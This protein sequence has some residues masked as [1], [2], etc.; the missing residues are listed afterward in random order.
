MPN[1]P[2]HAVWPSRLP[3]E[4]VIPATT[5]WFNLEVSARRYPDK[6]ACR[7]FGRDLSY[8]EL[9]AQAEALAGWL[10][11]EGLQAG[12]RVLLFLQNCPQFVV[13]FY[14]VQRA[15][16]VVVPV[17]PMNK[18][19]EFGHYITDPQARFAITSA[20]LAAIVDAADGRLP[21]DRR[22]H[23]MLVTRYC[24]AM[25]EGGPDPA[26][27]PSD[28]VLAWLRADPPL[29]AGAVRWRDALAA[30][31]SPGPHTAGPDDLAVL[32]YTSG[33]TGLP[34][35]CMHT[36]R[37]LMPNIV[38]GALWGHASAETVSLGVVP[39]FHITGLMYSV[40]GS[41]YLGSTVV[42]L[43]RWDR[44]LAGRL[45]S[46]HRVT[47]WTCIPTMIIDLFGSPYYRSFDLSRLRY[48]SGG[49]AAM[50]HAVAERL[51]QEFGL[52]FAEGY[53]LT[54]TAA[55]SHANPP[56]R[57]KL[58]CLGMPIFGVDSRVIDTAT[59]Q[60]LPA[61][62]VGEIVTHGPMVFKGYWGHPDATRDAFLQIDGK[63]FFRT[64][65]LGRMDEEG[66]FFITD[67]LKRM[68]NASGFKVWP[69]EVEL[70][71][72][73]CPAVQE[74]CVIA[75]TDAYRGESV[76]AVI[77]LRDAARGQTTGQDI[78]DWAREH[79]AAYKVP[80]VVQF[81]D[82]LPK[83]GSG[84]VMWRQLQEAEKAGQAG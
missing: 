16:A 52:T 63:A 34:K 20:D 39:M 53:G 82:S 50:P 30:R 70:L 24:E 26:E 74:A 77:V 80:R 81:A 68:I 71:L 27:A 64:G 38:G 47:H 66:Y 46:R 48:L 19:D 37:T 44:E 23:R 54:E 67:R 78:I 17:N 62:E 57:A 25:P 12:E 75:T 42:I 61:G 58:Q 59:L 65:D 36:H 41:V 49:G 2:H 31:H 11:A 28:A 55:P 10:M 69:S 13:A 35:G 18:A 7:F 29:P 32:P 22:L 6:A 15:N 51:Q 76:K 21:E 40:L 84:K 33:T 79:M 9:H 14:A 4:L 73:K 56:E 1:R 8:A 83:S 43:P 5:L 72:F 45:L 60:E 3:R